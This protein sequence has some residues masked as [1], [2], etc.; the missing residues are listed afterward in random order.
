MHPETLSASQR[1]RCQAKP[2]GETVM[3]DAIKKATNIVAFLI[4]SYA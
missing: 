1:H 4:S 2:S 3:Q